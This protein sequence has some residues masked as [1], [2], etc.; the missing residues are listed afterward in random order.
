VTTADPSAAEAKGDRTAIG[1]LIAD[2]RDWSQAADELGVNV[3][4]VRT[5]IREHHLA[6]AVPV[7]GE[8]QKIPAEFIQDGQ[9]VKGFQGCSP[10]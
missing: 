7:N 8:G 4:K 9:I 5:L 3:N 1:L 10:C 2:W 6:A